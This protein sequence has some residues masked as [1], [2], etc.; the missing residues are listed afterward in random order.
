M[1][2]TWWVND[3]WIVRF[4]ALDMNSTHELT[5]LLF[6]LDGLPNLL[7]LSYRSTAGFGELARLLDRLPDRIETGL[8][9]D[10][11][12]M[13]SLTTV[14]GWLFASWWRFQEAEN[15]ETPS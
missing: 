13:R 5:L 3:G 10:E 8:A 9:P 4:P 14:A 11:A 6:Q 1:Q 15:L 2:V 12:T 7:F